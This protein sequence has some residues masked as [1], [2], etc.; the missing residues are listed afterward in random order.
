MALCNANRVVHDLGMTFHPYR[1][2]INQQDET[3][4]SCSWSGCVLWEAASHYPCAGKEIAWLLCTLAGWVGW[5]FSPKPDYVYLNPVANEEE[6]LMFIATNRVLPTSFWITNMVEN[7]S[8]AKQ[9]PT[10]P[11]GHFPLLWFEGGFS[12]DPL[13]GAPVGETQLVGSPVWSQEALPLCGGIRLHFECYWSQWVW[14]V[15]RGLLR[16]S[17]ALSVAN[18]AWQGV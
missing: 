8:G 16:S 9:S 3:R 11:K 5:W 1:N 14:V 15:G 18:W 17:S 7:R 13:L 10:L 4:S 12:A 6:H 2:G